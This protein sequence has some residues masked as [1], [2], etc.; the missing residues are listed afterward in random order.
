LGE[1]HAGKIEIH[2][3]IP[4]YQ[5]VPFPTDSISSNVPAGTRSAPVQYRDLTL[6]KY[7][8]LVLRTLYVHL[9]SQTQQRD[10]RNNLRTIVARLSGDSLLLA[11]LALNML[12]WRQYLV[13]SYGD[14]YNLTEAAR[15]S[16]VIG[17][18]RNA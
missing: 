11:E 14:I 12:E 15:T 7:V 2:V 17:D 18:C 10:T 4:E 9:G 3:H 8:C 5:A 1:T 6:E 13:C 16:L